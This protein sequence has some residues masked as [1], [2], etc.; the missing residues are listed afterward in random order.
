MDIEGLTGIAQALAV[1]EAA[2]GGRAPEA[3]SPGE[4]L[5][6]NAAFG[7]LKRQVDAAF[8]PVAAEIARQSRVELGK[9]SLAKK[10][11]FRTPVALIQATT[12][13]SVGEAIKLVQVGE[14]TAPRTT[15][16]GEAL[17]ARHPHV[18]AGVA[19]SDLSITSSHAIVSL[20]DRLAARVDAAVLDE[21][22]RQLVQ[23]APGLRADELSR[24]LTHAEAILDPDG[25]E[26]RHEEQR[27]KRFLE[28]FE[29]DGAIHLNAVY[30]IA[31]GAPIKAFIDGRVSSTLLSNENRDDATRDERSV[32]QLR[33]DALSDLCAHG[34]ACDGIPSGVGAAIVVRVTLEELQSGVGTASIDGI[35]APLPVSALR[36]LACEVGVIPWVMGGDSE[37]LDWGRVKRSFTAAQKRAIAER[38][39]GC[40]CCGAS[41][42]WTHVHHIE[43]WCHGGTTDLSNGLLLCSAC[44]HRLHDDG[45]GVRIE[46]IGVAATVWFIPPPWIDADRTP[47]PSASRLRTLAA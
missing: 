18:A 24:L 15:L 26:P 11:G 17:P 29:R 10:Q 21:A 46:G 7:A 16:T 33:A 8:M 4:L 9:D 42:A 30:D 35:E 6:V 3:L 12:G 13:S 20:L 19:S 1:L 36:R 32:R 41:V 37:V 14:A 44:H 27:A 31:S 43:W 2:G 23:R 5:Q 39:R 34:I 38:D 22:E 28:V 25:V 47:R 40:A 45:W